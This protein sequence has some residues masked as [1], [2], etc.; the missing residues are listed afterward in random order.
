MSTPFSFQGWLGLPG[1][2]GL[3]ADPL[4]FG[5]VGDYASKASF[6]YVLP[7]APG[8]V[9]VDFGTMPT[10]GAKALLVT[11][12]EGGF[13]VIDLKTNGSSTPQELSPGGFLALGSPDPTV[14][15][16]ELTIEYTGT[17]VVRV[18]LLG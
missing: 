8:T 17:G 6:E 12:E 13:D 14:G 3:P 10:A 18:W 1:A 9:V 7:A 5:I 15:I 4:P 16:T 11:Y 2:P